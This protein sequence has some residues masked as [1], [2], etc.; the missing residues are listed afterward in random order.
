MRGR[1]GVRSAL[2]E[3]RDEADGYEVD[4]PVNPDQRL[5][6]RLVPYGGSRSMMMVRDITRLHTLEQ[7]RKDFVANVSHELR[8]P[9]SVIQ[10]NAET[11]AT[12]ETNAQQ[13]EVF[14]EAIHRNATRLS[15]IVADLLDLARIE[16][17]ELVIVGEEAQTVAPGMSVRERNAPVGARPPAE[18][19]SAD[20]FG[21]S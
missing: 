5:L 17:G 16:A 10:A 12:G 4:S 8:T 15:Q 6:L 11:L 3:R 7:M 18:D 2:L 20:P 1:L 21:A 9:I 19:A 14:L 13:S